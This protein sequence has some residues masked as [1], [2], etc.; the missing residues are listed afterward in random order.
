MTFDCLV[1][2]ETYISPS[3]DPGNIEMECGEGYEKQMVGISAV[4]NLFVPDMTVSVMN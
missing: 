2:S 3:Q 1:F 4:K